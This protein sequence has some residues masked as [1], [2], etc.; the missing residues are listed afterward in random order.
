MCS[1][2]TLKDLSHNKLACVL[3]KNDLSGSVPI[4]LGLLTQLTKLDIS[5]FFSYI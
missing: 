1:P 3:D 4:E 5:K 2:R